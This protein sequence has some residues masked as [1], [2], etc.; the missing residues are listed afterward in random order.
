MYLLIGSSQKE[1]DLL[2][3]GFLKENRFKLKCHFLAASY[4]GLKLDFKLLL[5][6]LEC[7]DSFGKKK[8][9]FLERPDLVLNC[10]IW[11]G[12]GKVK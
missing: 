5:K 3:F 7:S 2:Q 12:P 8:K 10:L 4:Y 9:C 6:I 1:L 11:L